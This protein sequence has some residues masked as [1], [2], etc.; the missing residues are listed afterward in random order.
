MTETQNITFKDAPVWQSQQTLVKILQKNKYKFVPLD[1]YGNT[2]F[3]CVVVQ[4]EYAPIRNALASLGIK[5][6]TRYNFCPLSITVCGQY[7]GEPIVEPVVF[8]REDVLNVIADV[9]ENY[10]GDVEL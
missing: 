2:E 8:T 9:P 7:K 1:E 10:V 3:T 5:T 4:E 6:K